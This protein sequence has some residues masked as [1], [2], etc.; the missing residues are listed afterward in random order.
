MFIYRDEYDL[1]QNS[2]EKWIDFGSLLKS[3]VNGVGSVMKLM[4]EP[5]SSDYYFDLCHFLKMCTDTTGFA[6]QNWAMRFV[7]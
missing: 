3:N 6:T 2:V 1:R 5:R 7:I 4:N